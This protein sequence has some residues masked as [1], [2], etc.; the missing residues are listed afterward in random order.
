MSEQQ[1]TLLLEQVVLLNA[2]LAELIRLIRAKTEMETTP[3]RV[4]LTTSPARWAGL[5]EP[6]GRHTWQQSSDCP[7]IRGGL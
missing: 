6:L 1:A 3:L 5:D 4:R 2:Q 7:T